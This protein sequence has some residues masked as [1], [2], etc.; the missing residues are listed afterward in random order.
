MGVDPVP[1]PSTM[2]LLGSGMLGLWGY[3]KKI[4]K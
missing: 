1:E 4:K 3:R 2:L